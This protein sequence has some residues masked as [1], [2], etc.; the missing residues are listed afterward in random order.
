[1]ATCAVV[2]V[3]HRVTGL[4]K[5]A[6]CGIIGAVVR[7][8]KRDGLSIAGLV[9]LGQRYHIYYELSYEGEVMRMDCSSNACAVAS[10][11]FVS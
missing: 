10:P 1:M 11:Q 7:W 6:S 2:L 9:A 5:Q 4:T 8:L 3:Y